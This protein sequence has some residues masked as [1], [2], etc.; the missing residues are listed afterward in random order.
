MLALKVDAVRFIQ[1]IAAT[2]VFFFYESGSSGNSL[3]YSL[4]NCEVG[5]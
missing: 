4:R 5:G 2:A 3:Q 1:I